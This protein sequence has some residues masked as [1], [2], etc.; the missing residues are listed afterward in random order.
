MRLPVVLTPGEDGWLVASCP[1]IP[2][3][4][5]QGRNREEALVNIQEAI[6]LCIESST[7]EGWRIADGFEVT[8]VSL[9]VPG[10]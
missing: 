3:C 8:E 7:E 5:S 9:S 1:L 10:V 4:I 2:G 6:A